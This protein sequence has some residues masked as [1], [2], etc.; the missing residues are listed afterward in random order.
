MTAVKFEN[1]VIEVT[2]IHDQTKWCPVMR[3][4]NGAWNFISHQ[5]EILKYDTNEEAEQ[6]FED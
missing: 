3:L 2:D 6:Y 1:K 4:G 5:G